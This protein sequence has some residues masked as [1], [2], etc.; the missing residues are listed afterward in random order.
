MLKKLVCLI[1]SHSFVS[2]G[3]CPVTAKSYIS[4]I[5]CGFTKE[6]NRVQ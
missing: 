5:L 2:I 6:E 4:C 3:S 1:K